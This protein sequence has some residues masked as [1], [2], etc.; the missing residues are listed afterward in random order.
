MSTAGIFAVFR[1]F[2]TFRIFKLIN[3]WKSLRILLTTAVKVIKD[4][5][6]FVVI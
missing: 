2:R 6:Y 1:I 3:N 5:R 4:M